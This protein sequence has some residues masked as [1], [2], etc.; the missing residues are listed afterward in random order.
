MAWLESGVLFSLA[1]EKIWSDYTVSFL[2]LKDE[3]R[4][5][6]KCWIYN[7]SKK[8]HAKLILDA[9]EGDVQDICPDAI[10]TNDF[11]DWYK[12]CKK[13][14]KNKIKK[15]LGHC[16]ENNFQFG[17]PVIDTLYGS[18]YPNMKEIR[19]GNAHAQSGKIRIIFAMD[20]NRKANI[21][22]GF[23][24][25]GSDYTEYIRIADN[26]FKAILSED[27]KEDGE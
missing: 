12:G 17:R 24:K 19:V 4:K 5:P 13:E 27:Q 20:P 18:D 15:T 10:F 23:I 3:E 2:V 16:C 14:D 1:T 7:I 8:R 21:L 26:L 9:M 22:S 6:D 11:I 25:H